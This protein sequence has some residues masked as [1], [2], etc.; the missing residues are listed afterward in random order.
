MNMW[1]IKSL[2]KIGH[3]SFELAVNS[4]APYL[5]E[6]LSPHPPMMTKVNFVIVNYRYLMLTGIFCENVLPAQ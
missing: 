6:T 3:T 1:V 5:P 4:L 2:S